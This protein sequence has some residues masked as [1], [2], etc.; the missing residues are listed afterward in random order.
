MSGRYR[1]RST[2][3]LAAAPETVFGAVVDLE[4]YPDWWADVRSVQKI[5]EDTAELVCRSVLPYSLVLRMR[6]AEQDVRAGRLRVDLSGDLEGVLAGS[7][8]EVDGGTRLEIVQEVV[9]H[10]ALIQRLDLVARPVFRANH[11]LMMQRGKRGLTAHLA[12]AA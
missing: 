7:V 5:D 2:W 8:C 9:A 6:R 4:K 1:F 10:K 11:A 12:A 3:L